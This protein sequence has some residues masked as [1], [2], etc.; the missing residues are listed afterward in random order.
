MKPADEIKRHLK[1]IKYAYPS[2]NEGRTHPNLL[3]DGY[4][5][6]KRTPLRRN[7]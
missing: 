6:G 3:H 5:Q 1:A 7:S 2:G 4:F